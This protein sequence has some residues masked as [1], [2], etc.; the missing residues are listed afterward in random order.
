MWVQ[1]AIKE[2]AT[3]LCGGRSGMQEFLNRLY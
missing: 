3:V 2:G 1:E